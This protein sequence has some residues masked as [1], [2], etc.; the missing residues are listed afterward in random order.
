MQ[1][2]I[3]CTSFVPCGVNQWPKTSQVCSCIHESNYGDAL[4][5]NPKTPNTELELLLLFI[6]DFDSPKI[7]GEYIDNL[8]RNIETLGSLKQHLIVAIAASSSRSIINFGKLPSDAKVALQQAIWSLY[9]L[10]KTISNLY[11]MDVDQAFSDLGYQHAYDDR[12]WYFA[13]FRLSSQGMALLDNETANFISRIISPPKKVLILDC[14][15]TLWGG[16][17]GEVGISGI[18]LGSDGLG[19]AFQDFQKQIQLLSDNGVIICLCSKNT[20]T[21]V[22]N[23][24]ENHDGMVLRWDEMSAIRVNWED[25]SQNI[26]AIAKDLDLDPASFVFWDDNP[27][28]REQVKLKLP[29]VSVVEAPSEVSEWKNTIQHLHE[30]SKFSVTEEDKSKTKQYKMRS[31]F[32]LEEK[33]FNSKKTEFLKTINLEPTFKRLDQSLVMR[34]SQ[35]TQKTTQFNLRT[36]IYSVKEVEDIISSS[37][38]YG[39]LCSA[40]DKFGDHGNVG[41]AIIE[42]LDQSTAFLNTFLF[43]CRVLGRDLEYWF[44]QRLLRCLQNDGINTLVSEYRETTRNEIARTFIEA[45]EKKGKCTRIDAN[46]ALGLD[47]NG[48]AYEFST[49]VDIVNVEGMYN[50]ED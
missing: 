28:E 8:V 44:L 9:N 35:M 1:L 16:V 13:H 30:F 33:S 15:N 25:K 49:N 17:V 34:A 6:D 47:P 46:R 39:F 45:L 24:F 27:L 3:F 5:F 41:F 7:F 42:R 12:N 4:Y 31:Q 36:E 21:D 11:V 37:E 38:R 40:K 43:S 18:E 20:E 29:M 10:T 2:S 14:D 50:H 48:L 32:I 23:V 26:A 19:A 22:K